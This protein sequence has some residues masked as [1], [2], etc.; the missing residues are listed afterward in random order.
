[1]T[2]HLYESG[3]GSYDV[4]ADSVLFFTADLSVANSFTIAQGSQADSAGIT[5]SPTSGL[6]TS[7]SGASVTFTVAL[8]SQPLFDVVIDLSSSNVNEGTPSPTALTFTDA[9]WSAPQTVTVTGVDDGLVDDDQAYTITTSACV[10]S[11]SDYDGVDPAN[12]SLTNLD[13]D[14]TGSGTDDGTGGSGCFVSSL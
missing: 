4:E 13:N 2:R 7:K 8:D 3:A 14:R 12:V 6:T 1:M 5:V 10:S 9:N 11:Y